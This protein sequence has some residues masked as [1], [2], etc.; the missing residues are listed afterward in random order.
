MRSIDASF[1]K[2]TI[3]DEMS[4]LKIN[5]NCM[6]DSDETKS[7]SDYV[8]TL[9]GG[10]VSWKSAKQTIISRFTMEAEIIVLDIATSEAEFLKNLLCDL[11]LLNKSIPPISTHCDSQVVISKV[12]NKN[13]KEDI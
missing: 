7:T 3:N 11:S 10:T 2:E 8:F 12:T 4:S 9:A 6:S 5:K 1:W 13:F